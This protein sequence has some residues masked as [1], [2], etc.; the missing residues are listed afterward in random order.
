MVDVLAAWS[1]RRKLGLAQP[2]RVHSVAGQ[3]SPDRRLAENGQ[4]EQNGPAKRVAWLSS[5]KRSEFSDDSVAAGT[6]DLV[7]GF[8]EEEIAPHDG[9]VDAQPLVEVIDAV[10]QDALPAGRRPGEVVGRCR[11][12]R[13]SSS[14][15][16]R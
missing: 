5:P 16:S 8:E 11:A 15:A 7:D 1:S 13:G 10:L 2:S 12:S 4:I 6:Q 9:L 3:A 14:A